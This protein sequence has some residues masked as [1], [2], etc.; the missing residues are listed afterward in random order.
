[1]TFETDTRDA[2][3]LY[4]EWMHENLARAASHFGLT[5]DGAPVFGW[6]DRSIGAVAVQGGQRRWLRVVTEMPE[7]AH[8][9]TW[10]GN[11]DAN[12]ITTLSKPRVLTAQEWRD[13]P[14]RHVRAEVMT[15]M[16]GHP[17]SATTTPPVDLV[18]DEEWWDQ[19]SKALQAIRE[20][21]T[22]RVNVDQAAVN[23]RVSTV[24]DRHVT[25]H[26]WETVHGDLH[27][28]NLFRDPFGLV[29]WELWGTG[30]VGTD[31]ATLY[32]YSLT[33]PVVA[34]EVRSRF[35][36]VLDTEAGRKAQIYVA[37][38]LLHRSTF[39]DHPELV[40]PLRQLVSRLTTGAP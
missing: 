37:A 25:V 36:A 4:R 24:L 33:E 9:D 26:H 23:K 29:D 22:R 20:V 30:P 3:R 27:W 13:N 6:L 12:L 35:A 5:V 32:L 10:A 19:L 1:M 11:V 14:H 2:D 15:T 17:C 7:W 28:G 40:S 39:G 16:A 8:G 18:L 38:R 21:D 34:N 31:A